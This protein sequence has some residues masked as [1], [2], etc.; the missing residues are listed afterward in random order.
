MPNPSGYLVPEGNK[1]MYLSDDELRRF[2]KA[3]DQVENEFRRLRD[4][5]MFRLILAFGL[6]VSEVPLLKVED[7]NGS[8]SPAQLRV[9]R[10]KLKP[11]PKSH[12]KA[13]QKKPRAQRWYDLSKEN[14]RAVRAWLAVRG[15]HRYAKDNPALFLTFHSD[16]AHAFSTAHIYDLV[17]DY[18]K[19][20]KLERHI[21][22]H[23]WRHTTAVKMAVAGMSAYDI[24][25]RLGHTSVLSG[26]TY[27]N[28]FGP[29]KAALDR[30][31]DH[32][33]EF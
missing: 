4:R 3:I 13:G 20:A 32:S 15:Q 12:P 33:L 1:I 10:V 22:P 21:W 7:F 24:M 9:T 29:E 14:E 23:M 11:F 18:A 17:R 2:F 30:K 25:H 19:A 5:A 26:Q 28:R 16:E 6:R 31:T 8:I 27:V